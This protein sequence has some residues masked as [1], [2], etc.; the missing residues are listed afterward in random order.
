[1]TVLSF[2]FVGVVAWHYVWEGILAPSFRME[3][4]M[5][6]FELRDQLRWLRYTDPDLDSRAY[7]IVQDAINN[8]ILFMGE[9]GLFSMFHIL[10]LV[11]EDKALAKRIEGRWEHVEQCKSDELKTINSELATGFSRALAINSG[12]WL[13]PLAF[14]ISAAALVVNPFKR[15]LAMPEHDATNFTRWTDTD[16]NRGVMA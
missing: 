15:F 14:L 10:S 5:R 13:I 12:A 4:R 1:M 6:Q 7:N 3:F 9:V 2:V 11:K 8:S 16:N